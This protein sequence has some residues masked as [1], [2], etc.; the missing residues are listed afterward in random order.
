MGLLQLACDPVCRT[1]PVNP[2]DPVHTP[3]LSMVG[4]GGMEL[5]E[6]LPRT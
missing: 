1:C 3:S 5:Q 6:V 4:G 2:W